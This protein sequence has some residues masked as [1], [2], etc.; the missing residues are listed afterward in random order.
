MTQDGEV[1]GLIVGGGGKDGIFIKQVVPESPAYKNLHVN[2]GERGR[3]TIDQGLY[4]W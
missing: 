1:E 2:E 3:I 4:T